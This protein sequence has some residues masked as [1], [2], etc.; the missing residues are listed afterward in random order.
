MKIPKKI[1]V[2]ALT[3]DVLFVE[4]YNINQDHAE[5]LKHKR[6]DAVRIN[7]NQ[8]KQ[9]QELSFVHEIVHAINNELSEQDTEFWAQ[10]I[11]QLLKEN[12]L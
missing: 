9:Q 7:K 4:D 3:Y 8:T 11:Y 10:A 2:G 12:K 5:L 6:F 1:K